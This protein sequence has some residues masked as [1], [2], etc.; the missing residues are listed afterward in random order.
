M[1]EM[2]LKLMHELNKK[3]KIEDFKKRYKDMSVKNALQIRD[4]NQLLS[5]H[6]NEVLRLKSNFNQQVIAL[7]RQSYYYKKCN[8]INVSFC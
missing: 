5:D 3:R 8:Q 7:R 4:K 2:T 1:N 6:K